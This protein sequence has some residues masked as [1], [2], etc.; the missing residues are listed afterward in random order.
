MQV[1]QRLKK[2]HG[3]KLLQRILPTDQTIWWRVYP[4]LHLICSTTINR[5]IGWS[6]NGAQVTD[7]SGK[8][9]R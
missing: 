6:K 5:L 7:K 4:M 9:G 2:Q 8:Q 1:P 3:R